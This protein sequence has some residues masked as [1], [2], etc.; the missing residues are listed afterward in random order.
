LI[1]ATNPN[2]ID[3]NNTKGY[4]IL[5]AFKA[6]D[7]NGK[8][9]FNYQEL[10]TFTSKN[11]IFLSNSEILG[12][13]RRANKSGNGK[14]TIQEFKNYLI[15]DPVSDKI[16]DNEGKLQDNN[17][18]QAN[19]QGSPQTQKKN[20]GNDQDNIATPP[21][22]YNQANINAEA[23]ESLLRTPAREY[24][25]IYSSNASAYLPETYSP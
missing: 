10:D 25:P 23:K 18:T 15:S 6:I 24:R 3:L 8:G 1:R 22:N 19:I 13:F 4:T 7:V 16:Y 21:R 11:G 12:I 20:I 2:K 5:D 17:N 9:S 14:L